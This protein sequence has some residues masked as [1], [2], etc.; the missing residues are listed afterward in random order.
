[1][2]QVEL[3]EGIMAALAKAAREQGLTV[4]GWIAAHLPD[5]GHGKQAPTEAEIRA[6]DERLEACI[7]DYGRPLGID[8]QSIDAD[9]ARVY[10]DAS[11]TVRSDEA[12]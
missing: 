10:G 4:S 9:L 8:N 12:P 6:A 3:S 7:T 1:M 2:A 5:G 11:H